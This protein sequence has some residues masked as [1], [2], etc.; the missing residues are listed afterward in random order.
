MLRVGVLFVALVGSLTP[1]AAAEFLIQQGD[2]YQDLW[3]PDI[4]MVGGQV[5]HL[6]L[7]GTNH[8]IE[9]GTLGLVELEEGDLYVRGGAFTASYRGRQG[10]KRTGLRTGGHATAVTFEGRYF[11]L[12]DAQ[13]ANRN[14]YLIEGW[15][16]DGSFVSLTLNN[17]LDIDTQ[18][19]PLNFVIV[20]GP[21]LPGDADGDW[22]V[23]LTD[24]N[25]IRNN[26]GRSGPGDTDG[27]G[28]V[29]LADLNSLRNNFGAGAFRLDL[30][31]PVPRFPIQE[32]KS[33]MIVPVATA[34]PEPS[35]MV[36]A[37]FAIICGGAVAWADHAKARRRRCC[38]YP[39]LPP[40]VV[41]SS[42]AVVGPAH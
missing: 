36:L 39:Q 9:G 34:V 4:R 2:Y 19:L 42:S 8:L 28:S 25:T 15:L 29:D 26:F 40:T 22:D 7:L 13:L 33:S 30:D 21:D 14:S 38:D 5:D 27:S 23:D 20:P 18:S 12:Y 41:A 32:I 24:M 37:W 35:S 11:R 31:H 10:I 16:N 3:A 17:A 6:V 1:A